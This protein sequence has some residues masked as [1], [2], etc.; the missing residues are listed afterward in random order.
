MAIFNFMDTCKLYQLEVLAKEKEKEFQRGAAQSADQF[1]VT[2]GIDLSPRTRRPVQPK[3]K[4]FL[5]RI[6]KR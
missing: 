6:F 3:K 1:E 2:T 5:Q 4:N